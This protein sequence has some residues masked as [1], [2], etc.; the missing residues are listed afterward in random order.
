V[1]VSI[2]VPAYNA[3]RTLADTLAS[4]QGQSR[5]G[6]EAV[7]VD[8]GSTDGTRALAE[9][10]A[11]SDARIRIVSQ[12]NGGEGAARNAG[13][14]AARSEW[15][16]F[17]DADDR[18]APTY[19]ERMAEAVAAEPGLDAVHCGWV[20]IDA[21][22]RVFQE[23]ECRETGD[24]FP[25]LARRN[26]FPV[27]A[28]TVRRALVEEVGRFDTSLRTCADWD[29]W[30]RVARRG[31]RFGRASGPLA[32]YFMR[33]S[34]TWTS[35]LRFFTDGCRVIERGH[36]ADPRV[37]APDPLH[38]NGL[39]RERLA[40]DRLYFACL[41]AGMEIARAGNARALLNLLP[42]DRDPHLDPG[43][44]SK[45]LFSSAPLPGCHSLA[46]W[47]GLWPR[48]QDGIDEFLSAL[49]RRSGAEGLARRTRTVLERLVLE[50]APSRR[51]MT[52]GGTLGVVIE[53]TEPVKDIEAVPEVT[54]VVCDVRTGGEHAGTVELPVCG[55]L[56]PAH[57]VADAILAAELPWTILGRFFA[58]TLYPGLRA[59]RDETG[60]SLWRKDVCLARSLSEEEAR[61]ARTLHDRVGWTVFLQELWG[62]PAWELGRFY[63]RDAKEQGTDVRRVP[64]SVASVEAAT[65]LADLEVRGRWLDVEFLLGGVPI[66]FP[67][68]R[69]E[70]GRVS[71][72]QLRV[73]L[74]TQAGFELCRAAVRE[75]LIG[76]PL[77]GP[78]T[79]R[80]RLERRAKASEEIEEG[81]GPDPPSAREV[82][83]SWRRVVR[84]SLRPGQ[85]GVVL[86]RHP[87]SPSAPS[88]S[89]R[90]SL[91]ADSIADL[92]E[93]AEA[94][95]HPA[96]QVAGRGPQR[97]CYAP[98]LLWRSCHETPAR[99][100]TAR[101]ALRKL[102]T[103]LARILRPA[104]SERGRSVS[105]GTATR[106][107]PILMYHQVALSGPPHLARYRVT[108]EA[109]EQQLR[110]L[111][112][113]GFRATTLQEWWQAMQA[114]KPLPGRAVLLTFD[115]GFR[116][117]HTHAWPLLRR[118][119]FSATVFLIAE[120]VGTVWEEVPGDGVP[121]LGWNHV[122]RLQEEGV[123]FG[124]HTATHPY[125][126]ALPAAEVVREAA[127]SRVI[128]ARELGSP[129]DAL[130]YPH[131]AHDPA[132]EHLVGACGYLFGLSCRPGLSR[133]D[134]PLLALPR[135]E[136]AG[137]DG[138]GE[139]AAKLDRG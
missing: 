12:P 4:V 119:G 32:R 33:P 56:V 21:S 131:G 61:D 97:I 29:L 84:R 23:L 15:L 1:N 122:R 8:D 80:E 101:T 87:A 58:A 85:S 6:W 94:T 92:L 107:L 77:A 50:A 17:L 52:V 40:T 64:G 135:V 62:R 20:L 127:R 69:V 43:H 22:G 102:R 137:S 44:V 78:A 139:F 114:G 91:P 82:S 113:E 42:D 45:E 110:H 5:S 99:K 129:P 11:A 90:A 19:V 112:D 120:R 66:A 106:R 38:A 31:A 54:R 27:H 30:Q 117:F 93:L 18:I 36:A 104:A 47:F 108:P 111:R 65:E 63:D 9:A 75:G 89:R 73:A 34:S 3:E 71:A 123:A 35:D 130:A 49:E 10:A 86:G 48:L 83:P 59:A 76:A 124:S 16:L 118:Y 115:D 14:A 28:C 88:P 24:L 109:F 81:A 128:L 138:I 51:P 55:G 46:E 7:V 126:T 41:C 37:A 68:V 136:V 98:D 95:G 132:V 60:V 125:L 133:L 100:R 70:E 96:I 134:D 67:R 13:I 53:V 116:D 25:A 105:R 79:L 57:V 2:I 74:A 103:T 72:Q 39:P 26:V 121:L